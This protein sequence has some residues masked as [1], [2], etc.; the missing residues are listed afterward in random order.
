MSTFREPVIGDDFDLETYGRP[1]A[2]RPRPAQATNRDAQPRARASYDRAAA[3]AR[4]AESHSPRPVAVKATQR[5]SFSDDG[6]RTVKISGQATPPRR[7]SAQ[8]SLA[9]QLDRYDRRPDRAAQWALFMGVFM[10][11]VAIATGS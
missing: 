8:R 3:R 6:V 4:R 7:R 9:V 11:V 1:A 10:I 2:Q 5:T